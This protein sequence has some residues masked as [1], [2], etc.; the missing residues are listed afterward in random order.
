MPNEKRIHKLTKAL[1]AL[2]EVTDDYLQQF[3]GRPR[4]LGENEVRR[5][6]VDA[7][8]ALNKWKR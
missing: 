6:Y 8:Y 4:T 2:V 5:R 3:E 1:E 7:M